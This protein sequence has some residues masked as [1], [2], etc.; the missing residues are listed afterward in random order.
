MKVHAVYEGRRMHRVLVVALC[1]RASLVLAQWVDDCGLQPPGSVPVV[2]VP[3][4]PWE[5]R[6]SATDAPIVSRVIDSN[7]GPGF[8][9]YPTTNV[10]AT[11]ALSGKTVY[12][13][14]GHGFTWT[15]LG[16]S[17]EWRTQRPATNQIVEDLVSTETLNQYLIPM[18]IGAGAHVVSVREADLNPNL[19]IVDNGEAGYSEQGSATF[20]NSTRPG[21]GR[22]PLPMSGDVLPFTVGTNRLMSSAS[23]VTG[24]VTYTVAIPADGYYN[25][26]IS[27]SAFSTRV[28]D[29]HYVVHHAGGAT[30][31]RV[32]Q[33]RH[34]A[35]WEL[36]GRFYFHAGPTTVEVLNDSASG[37]NTYIS[38]DAIRFGGGAGQ[39]TRTG[40]ATGV[41]GRPRFEESARYHAQFAGAPLDVFAPTDNTPGA[42]RTN[43]IGTRSRFAAWV[44]EPG[45]DAIYVAWHTNAFDGTAVGTTTY[46]YGPNPPDGS[47]NFTGVAGSDDLAKAVH[48]ELI[49][50]IKAPSGW[51]SPSWK[52]RGVDSAY[53]GELNPTNNSETPAILIEVA[54]HDAPSD[55]TQLKEPDFRQLA[56]RAITQGIIK[57]FAK[58]DGV[59]AKLPPEP[60]ARL[61]VTNQG[62]GKALLR[63]ATG[64]TDSEG[65]RGQAA[66][67][68]R[69]YSS[70][71]GLGWDNGVAVTG[72]STMVQVPAAAPKYFR[73]TGC[74]RRR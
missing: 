57:Y 32:N 31:F 43:D 42:D 72:T 27:Y 36:L 46:V 16:S 4:R 51:N 10:T 50:D 12:L 39:I 28:T 70:D 13:S 11:G 14:P 21:W 15:S 6:V 68:F 29:A 19:V 26:S 24:T 52:D 65:V 20:Q 41:S 1:L 3:T 69:V 38:L 25:V 33:Q 30:H 71:D 73:V 2:P 5:P 61:S 34:G 74:E 54:F 35:T 44:H 47:Y 8:G 48:A 40:N 67:S 55:S 58:K 9:G 62:G 18:L 45:E 59:M 7:Q 37:P 23:T 17:F 53:F 22:S 60:P 56:A 63:W 66:T 49:S 64:A